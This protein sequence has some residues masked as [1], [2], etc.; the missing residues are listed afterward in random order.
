MKK[1]LI[2]III[3]FFCHFAFAQKIYE[4]YIDGQIYVKFS[5]RLLK[6]FTKDNPE[7]LKLSKFGILSKILKKYAVYKASKPYYHANDDVILSNIIRFDFKQIKDVDA[8]IS[9][10]KSILGVEYAEKVPLMKIDIAPNDFSISSASVH[11]N[12][13]NAQ[14]AWNIFN[15]NSNIIVAIVDNAVMWSHS[16]LVGNTFTNSI[17]ANGTSGIDDDGNGYIDDINGYDVADNDNNTIPSNN[18][19]DHGTHCAG[20]AGARNDNG[21]GIASIGWNIKILPVKCTSTSLNSIDNGYGGIIYAVKAKARVIS[22]SWGGSGFSITEQSVINYAWNNGCIVI[23]S[24]GNNSN[25]IQNYPGAYA[26]SYCVANVGPNNIK[27]NS[28]SFGTW[29]DICAPGQNIYSTIPNSLTG[30]YGFKSGTS[31]AAPMV[32][33]LAGLM[34][35]KCSYMTQSDVLNCISNNAVNIYTIAANSSYSVGNQLGIGRIEAYQAMLCAASYSAALPICNFYSFPRNS[36]PNTLINFIDSSLY[37]PTSWVWTFQNGTPATSTLSNPSVQWNLPGVYSVSL[38]VSNVNGNNSINKLSYITIN[39]PISLPFSEGFE[40]IQFLPNNWTANNILNDNMYWERKIGFGAFG[41]STACVCYDNYNYTT[42]GT[43]DEMR[44]P[45]Y[46][47]SNVINGFLKFDVAY[48]RYDAVNSDTLEVKLS[49]NCGANWTTIYLKGGLALA[50]GPDNNNLFV[51]NSNQWRRD[52]INISSLTNN[53]GNVMF[54]FINHGQFGQPI[55]L[56][57]INLSFPTP[58]LSINSLTSSCSGAAITMTNLSTSANSYTWSFPG[59][60]PS[61]SSFTNPIV[62][63][64]ASGIYTINLFGVN[65]TSSA[66]I[67]RT[68]AISNTTLNISAN[69][70]MMCSGNSATI[71]VTGATSY[72]W[73]TGSLNSSIVVSPTVT[74]SFSVTGYTG[75]CYGNSVIT[76]SITQAPSLSINVQPSNTICLGNTAT[77]SAL[78]NYTNFIWTNFNVNNSVIAVTPSTNTSYTVYASGNSGNCNT[79]SLVSIQINTNPSSILSTTNSY[80][81]NTCTGILNAT[82]SLGMGP[83]TYSLTNGNCNVLPC[84]SLCT[85]LYQIITTDINGCKS[86][87]IFSIGNLNSNCVGI[88]KTEFDSETLVIYPNPT[89]NELTIDYKMGSYN[90]KIYSSLGQLLREVINNF[91]KIKID[92]NEFEKGI[93]FIEIGNENETIRKKLILE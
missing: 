25:N 83:Y 53:Q 17:E 76:I 40:T 16:D 61:T 71:N 43:R 42:A 6:G 2:I 26:N 37:Q 67:S 75:N 11:L 60:N 28:S 3:S 90:Y 1:S 79:N 93:Y 7:N 89:K 8:F 82:T 84:N 91:N 38:T 66:S 68:I 39:G 5:N 21:L 69:P 20:I 9:E 59:G 63:Y 34:L 70:I 41:S 62:T 36:C 29:V 45:K 51:P 72:S 4:D 52:S 86:I 27:A 78:G 46:I 32:A 30:T 15:G 92:V 44:T 54:S 73:N 80:C 87:N 22:C 57:N 24:A 50:T 23:A 56:D 81:E 85:G 64:S 19:M 33:G 47:F 77:I 18:L 12:Q 13:I 55:Y 88:I 48:E 65:G 74:S 10:L 14:N 58:T 35:S 31:M 49:N